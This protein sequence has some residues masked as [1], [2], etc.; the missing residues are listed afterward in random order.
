M[1]TAVGLVLGLAVVIGVVV[2]LTGTGDD[3]ETAATTSVP[4]PTDLPEDL[5]EPVAPVELPEPPPGTTLTDDTPCPPADGADDRVQQF[6][7]PPPDCLTPG[8]SYRATFST[9]L[10]DFTAE[11]DVDAAPATVNNFVV[12]SR[13]R[14]YHGVPFHRIVPGFVIQAGDGDGPPWGSND[15]G[16]TIEDELPDSSAAYVDYS[17]AMANAGPDTNGSQF[18]VVLPDGG[19]QLQPLYSHFGQ[20]VEGQDIVDAIAALGGVGEEPTEVVLIDSVTISE[21]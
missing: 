3:D 2:L 20:V 15:L 4:D 7:G 10:G 5:P 16:Y 13:Y 8:A 12:L 17:L 9:T 18:F 14:Y 19:G 11:L 6:A 21:S 1:L